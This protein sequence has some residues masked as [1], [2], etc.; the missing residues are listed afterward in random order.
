MQR[1]FILKKKE[2][3]KSVQKKFSEVEDIKKFESILTEDVK[4]IRAQIDD[5]SKDYLELQKRFD[6]AEKEYLE[7]KVELFT[8]G[9]EKERLVETLRGIIE[10]CESEKAKKLSQLLSKFEIK[11]KTSVESK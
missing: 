8:K 1:S 9:E 6:R 5:I 4:K 10:N 2:E 3:N 7:A 11:S